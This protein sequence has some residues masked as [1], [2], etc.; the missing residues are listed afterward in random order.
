M[1]QK[2]EDVEMKKQLLMMAVLVG[3]LITLNACCT[4]VPGKVVYSDNLKRTVDNVGAKAMLL[5]KEDGSVLIYNENGDRAGVSKCK[6]PKPSTESMDKKDAAQTKK[7]DYP[8]NVCKGLQAGSAVTSIQ[9]L[10]ILKT[11]SGNC[12]VIAYDHNGDPIQRCW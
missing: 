6:Y 10:S 12:L 2:K 4:L 8:S 5:V 9:S 1:L 7:K 3:S 11:N